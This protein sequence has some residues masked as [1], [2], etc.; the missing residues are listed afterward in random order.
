M[1]RAAA[2]VRPGERMPN[3]LVPEQHARVGTA[4]HRGLGY[5]L[6]VPGRF[7]ANQRGKKAQRSLVEKHAPDLWNLGTTLDGAT[8]ETIETSTCR[9]FPPSMTKP[10][11][12]ASP[13]S[14]W[15]VHITGRPFF[16]FPHI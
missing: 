13:P 12:V 10:T 5:V 7:L 8:A 1:G 2:P 14:N 4:T 3:V 16:F 15:G 9:N 6:R 11:S